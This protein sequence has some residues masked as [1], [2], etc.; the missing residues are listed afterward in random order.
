MA[1]T[2]GA[3]PTPPTPEPSPEEAALQDRKRLAELQRDI[4]QA[5]QARREAELPVG[6][7][8]TLA[9]TTTLDDKAGYLAEMV[10]YEAMTSCAAQIAGQIRGLRLGRCKIL[11]VDS[12]SFIGDDYHLLQINLRLELFGEAFMQLEG[13]LKEPEAPAG[14]LG[15]AAATLASLSSLASLMAGLLGHF[16]SNYELKGRAVALSDE[17]LQAKVAGELLRDPPPGLTLERLSFGL[18]QETRIVERL[19]HL[20]RRRFALEAQSERIAARLPVQ[21]Q[22]VAEFRAAIEAKQAELD[23]LA[24]NDAGRAPLEQQIADA[25]RRLAPE[26]AALKRLQ[27]DLAE[28]Q[29][30]SKAFDAFLD[31]T[32]T[33]Q[34]GEQQTPALL[35]AMLRERIRERKVTHLLHLQIVSSGGETITRQNLF[36]RGRVTFLGG[37]VAAYSLANLRGELLAAGAPSAAAR[38]DYL[39]GSGAATLSAVEGRSGRL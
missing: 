16:R 34:G 18:L 14:A 39:L 22:L 36:R 27:G 20:F 11:L 6:G 1:D 30:V 9:G 21:E 7:A 38:L 31:S 23:A 12:L 25:K 28:W 37:C 2:N 32:V 35:L 15:G 29:A 5:D 26:E 4:A 13:R 24:A 10:A 8:T 3:A 17:A 19:R 33:P